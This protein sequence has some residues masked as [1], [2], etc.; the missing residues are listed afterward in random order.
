MDK[1]YYSFC[2]VQSG[3]DAETLPAFKRDHKGTV[4]HKKYLTLGFQPSLPLDIRSS[5]DAFV[6]DVKKLNLLE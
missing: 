1:Y 5:G 3:D 2:N 6:A 4:L